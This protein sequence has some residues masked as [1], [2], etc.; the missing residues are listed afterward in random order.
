MKNVKRELNTPTWHRRRADKLST[1]AARR[2]SK[3]D[4]VVG[5]AAG[6]GLYPMPDFCDP[7]YVYNQEHDMSFIYSGNKT[8][9]NYYS[10]FWENWTRNWKSNSSCNYVFAHAFVYRVCVCV[11]ICLTH[12]VMCDL[13]LFLMYYRWLQR[14]PYYRHVK[15][16]RPWRTSLRMRKSTYNFTAG[17]FLIFGYTIKQTRKHRRHRVSG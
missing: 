3:I 6:A 15:I 1:A 5:D 4:D 9:T 17:S 2:S 12:A 11:Y 10:I 8:H 13:V 7:V 16:N 14:P